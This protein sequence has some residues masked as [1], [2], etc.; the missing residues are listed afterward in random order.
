MQREDSCKLMRSCE[1]GAIDW[2]WVMRQAAAAAADDDDAR[3]RWAAAVLMANTAESCYH[4]TPLDFD[5]KSR[6]WRCSINQSNNQSITH[7]IN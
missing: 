3:V 6:F 4:V 7:S 2:R 1:D 5:K